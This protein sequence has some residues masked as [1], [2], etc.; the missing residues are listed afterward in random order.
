MFRPSLLPFLPLTK[1]EMLLRA[2]A[3]HLAHLLSPHV[4][5]SPSLSAVC[6]LVAHPNPPA[7]C[8]VSVCGARVP[9]LPAKALAL[10]SCN[11]SPH[12]TKELVGVM[13]GCC[14]AQRAV[15]WS[16]LTKKSSS[17]SPLDLTAEFCVAPQHIK[18]L[19]IAPPPPLLTCIIQELQLLARCK[20]E[21]NNII[22]STLPS[23]VSILTSSMTIHV[24]YINQNP[25]LPI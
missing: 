13:L 22:S 25:L 24:N 1:R 17:G 7:L 12:P 11:Y 23:L 2:P 20:C 4:H 6:L 9:V 16:L 21:L 5:C 19:P 15:Q 10:I 18:L 8:Y 14:T 3:V